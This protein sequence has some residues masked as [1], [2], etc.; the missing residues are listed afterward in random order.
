MRLPVTAGPHVPVSAR[1][2]WPTPTLTFTLSTPG[3]EV[4]HSDACLHVSPTRHLVLA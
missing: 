3:P 2:C 1:E 4:S